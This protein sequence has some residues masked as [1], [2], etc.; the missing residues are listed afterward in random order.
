VT[1]LER[2]VG[3][4]IAVVVR[5]IHIGTRAQT[6][7]HTITLNPGGDGHAVRERRECEM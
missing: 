5:G 1:E 3:S 2:K 7:L 6:R 4:G